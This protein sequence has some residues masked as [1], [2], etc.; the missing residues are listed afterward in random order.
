MGPKYTSHPRVLTPAEA[1]LA[2]T[3][4]LL[5]YMLRRNENH[6]AELADLLDHLPAK[7]QEQLLMAIGTYEA[8]NVELREVLNSISGKEPL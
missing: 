4:V 7:A 1:D 8:A 3:R 5:E 6:N 2:Q